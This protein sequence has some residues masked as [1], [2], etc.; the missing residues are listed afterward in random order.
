MQF[1]FDQ[2]T[3]AKIEE[4]D[5]QEFFFS[6]FDNGIKNPPKAAANIVQ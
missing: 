2:A 1:T 3:T 6:F 4:E 5:K